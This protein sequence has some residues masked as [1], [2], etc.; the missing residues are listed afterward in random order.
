MTRGQEYLKLLKI[1]YQDLVKI[2]KSHI[3]MYEYSLEHYVFE[4]E[5]KVTVL[6]FIEEY[7]QDVKYY[8]ESLRL[9][10]GA[11]N[12]DTILTESKNSESPRDKFVGISCT[13][14]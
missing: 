3:A 12:E 8:S 4:P 9:L 10:G 11:E 14:V 13:T 1:E 7:K 6:K 2:A 5:E